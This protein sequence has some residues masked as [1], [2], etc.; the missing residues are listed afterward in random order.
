MADPSVGQWIYPSVAQWIHCAVEARSLADAMND[1]EAKRLM[2]G[3][4]VR[5]ERLAEHAATLNEWQKAISG[6][7]PPPAVQGAP[8]T[9]LLTP[10]S[11]HADASSLAR[12]IMPE[13]AGAARRSNND[14]R[15]RR[16]QAG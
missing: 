13:P 14:R 8:Q 11:T 5:Y 3:I 15:T 9:V 10:P 2:L 1:P 4:A 16:P 7:P 12:P 6:L